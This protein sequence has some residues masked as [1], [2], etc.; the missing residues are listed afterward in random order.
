MT[1]LS[2]VAPVLPVR[3][4]VSALAHYRALGFEVWAYEGAPYGYARRG[5][6]HLHLSE[7]EGLDP[8]T[9][10]TSVYLDVDDADSL[11]AEWAS[12]AM[13]GR[14]V[15]AVDTDYG[16]REGAHVDPDGQPAP[17]RLPPSGRRLTVPNLAS[18]GDAG[19]GG[20]AAS[21]SSRR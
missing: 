10:M 15:A 17:L 2:S 18:P 9:S 11:A 7:V 6:V 5:G 3:D 21:A 19:P 13:G 12:A 8:L 14:L 4:I 20:P 16:L 1:N